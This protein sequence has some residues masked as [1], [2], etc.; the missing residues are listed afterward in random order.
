MFIFT[1]KSIDNTL[2][3]NYQPLEYESPTSIPKFLS[4]GQSYRAVIGDTINLPCKTQDLGLETINWTMFSNYNQLKWEIIL[5]SN[6][7]LW[8]RGSSVVTAA[9]LMITRDTRFRLLDEYSLQ[10]KGV[11]PQDAGDYICQIGD[12]ENRDLVHTVE[13]LV[14]PTV[15]AHPETGHV[16]ARKGSTV[17]LECKASGNPVPSITWVKRVRKALFVFIWNK[18]LVISISIGT[19]IG[20]STIGWGT[21]AHVGSRWKAIK[22]N[23]SLHS[24]QWRPRS[25]VHWYATLSTMWV[26]I[27]L[28]KEKCM[29]SIKMKSEMRFD[30]FYPLHV[31]GPS[32]NHHKKEGN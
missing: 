10:I 25:S 16:T 12:Q 7:L 17:S 30:L 23:L 26:N 8:R 2:S 11:R 27:R 29:I 6:I 20:F 5:G 28:H 1:G 9:T 3:Q 22:W 24:W 19:L 31:S 15:R 4:R 21:N 13:I 14:P 18:S 32:W